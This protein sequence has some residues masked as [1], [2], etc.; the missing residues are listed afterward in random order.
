MANRRPLPHSVPRHLPT[1][2]SREMHDEHRLQVTL[3]LRPDELD[4]DHPVAQKV[5]HNRSHDHARAIPL[6]LEELQ[7]AHSPHDD[8]V[9][10]VK[11]F[12]AE[13]GLDV[14]EV[15]DLRH[16]VVLEGPAQALETAFEVD[17]QH[18]DH[19]HGTYHGHDGAVHLP[20]ELHDIVECVLGLDSIPMHGRPLSAP[21]A[22]SRLLNPLDIGEYYKLPDD[23]DGTNQRI[24]VLEFAGGYHNDDMTEFFTKMGVKNPPSIRDVCVGGATN[25]PLDVETLKRYLE[26]YNESP[27]D[28]VK[29]F[30]METTGKFTSTI[31]VTMDIQIIAALAPGAEIDV[32]F[33]PGDAQSYRRGIFA[34]LG[35]SQSADGKPVKPATVMSISWGSPEEEASSSQLSGVESALTAASRAGVT[36]CCSS[37]DF[38]SQ[39]GSGSVNGVSNVCFPASS[40]HALACGGTSLEV[41]NG[42][43][44]SETA[45][46]QEIAA[47]ARVAS[48]G[49][50]SGWFPIEPWQQHA[51][52]P[53]MKDL[54]DKGAWKGMQAII[55]DDFRGRGVPDVA[56]SAN[57]KTGYHVI[58][59]GVGT[60]GGGTSAAAPLWAALIARINQS[61]GHNVGWITPVIYKPEIAGAF[62]SVTTGDNKVAEGIPFFNADEGWNGCTGVGTPHGANLRDA[63]RA[64]HDQ[65]P[66]APG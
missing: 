38:G 9:E 48:T 12:A 50:V 65:N 4:D 15:S 1:A 56:S 51:P 64:L 30:G 63:L 33:V 19:D 21:G 24:A 59:G 57:L 60:T 55:N 26:V 36:V 45:W 47:G 16:D 52:V 8:H 13:H 17:L 6:T 37:G 53:A 35:D 29:E 14:V 31:E 20:E 10:A 32:Y 7:A 22:A 2:S 49:G 41:E 42:K 39:G 46:N 62:R 40:P 44:V 25:N 34:A 23:A 58:L 3:V 28:A 18:Y 5:A 54:P 61:L 27:M 11:E 66:G 43:P